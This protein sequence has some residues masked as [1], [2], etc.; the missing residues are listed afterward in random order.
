MK[1]RV[2]LD[3]TDIQ[4]LVATMYNVPTENVIVCISEEPQG[5]NEEMVPV[6]TVEVELKGE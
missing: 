5:Y 3:E 2:R 4:G 6:L 1:R